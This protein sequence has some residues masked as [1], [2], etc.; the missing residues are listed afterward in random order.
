MRTRLA[1]LWPFAP[2]VLTT[3]ACLL[4]QEQYPFSDFPMYSRFGR[5]THYIYLADGNAQP[6]PSYATV[7]LSTATLKK[8]YETELRQEARRLGTRRGK[9]GDEPK[10][11]AAER[12]LSGF[13]RS[14]ASGTIR[15]LPPVLR[16]YEVQIRLADAQLQNET[17][18]VA[19]QR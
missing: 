8:M 10:R 5:G 18:L 7:G 12:L 9:L 3:A 17:K 2:L 11:L 15:G 4:I 1:A 16:L 13:R 19:E 14:E 6:L